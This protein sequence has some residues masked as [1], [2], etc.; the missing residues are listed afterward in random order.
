MVK[1]ILVVSLAALAL[2]GCSLD[3]KTLMG[4][5][6]VSDEQQVTATTTPAPA[7]DTSLEAMP[8]PG[9]GSDDATLETDVNS[10]TIL[11]EDFSDL[12]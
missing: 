5:G 9:T 7:T 6:A 2:G 3:L 11:E 12:E 8:S 10:T 4:E 1:K